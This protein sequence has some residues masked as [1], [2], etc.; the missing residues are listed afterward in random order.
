MTTK[1]N[2]TAGYV[3]KPINWDKVALEFCFQGKESEQQEASKSG[4]KQFIPNI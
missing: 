3:N 1:V 2:K 4:S